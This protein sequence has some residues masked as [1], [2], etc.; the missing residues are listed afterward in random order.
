MHRCLFFGGFVALW[1]CGRIAAAIDP[2]LGNEPYWVLLHEPAVIDELNF[3]GEQRAEYR[4][5]LDEW[6]LR[7]FPLRNKPNRDAI[8]GMTQ[9]LDDVQKQLKSV[10]RTEQQTRLNE[11]LYQFLGS[12]AFLRDDVR[13]RLRYSETQWKRIN[14][15]TDETQKSVAKLMESSAD[16]DSKSAIDK[17]YQSLKIDEQKKLVSL[18]KPE[19]QTAARSMFGKPFAINELRKPAFKVPELVDTGDWINSPGLRPEDLKGKVVVVH[20]Y[21]CGCINCIH[22][23]PWY[24]QWHDQFKDRNVVMIG[25]HTPETA[26]ERESATVRRKAAEEKLLFPI[27]IDGK[28]ENWNAWGNSMWPS[29]YLIDQQGYLREFWPG[30]LNWKGAEGETYIRER[31]EKLLK[32]QN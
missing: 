12:G 16:E 23:Y 27:L 19:Q 30:E 32:E 7:F 8:A 10:L 25:I 3:S 31:I 20:F 28:S 1:F 11:I 22:N 18:L 6:D 21:A 5:L 17:K 24:R 14:E 2:Y 15:I 9:I 29:V 13:A 4:R 26:G